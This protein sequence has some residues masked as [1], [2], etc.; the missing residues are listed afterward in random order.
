[1]SM[2]A[3]TGTVINT[4][5]QDGRV[6]KDTGEKSPN[7]PKVQ[8]LGDIPVPTGGSRVDL[9]TLTIPQGMDFKEHLQQKVTV[10]LGFFAPQKNTII[11]Y[12]PKGSTIGN[13]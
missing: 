12:I 3:I 10:P 5:V 2:F 7:V 9:V 8:I 13:A 4:F 6:D 1:M 11:Y